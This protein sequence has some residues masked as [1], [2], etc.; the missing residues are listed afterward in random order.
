MGR[1]GR[2]SKFLFRF[3]WLLLDLGGF[4]AKVKFMVE[5]VV[6]D[7]DVLVEGAFW[8]VRPLAGVNGASV[9]SFYLVSCPTEALLFVVLTPLPLLDILSL[10]LKFAEAICKFVAFVE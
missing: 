8:A 5:F 6:L 7:L 1:V 4:F 2:F 10:A 3:C 9:M